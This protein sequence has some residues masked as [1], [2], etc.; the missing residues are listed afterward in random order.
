MKLATLC[1]VQ[2]GGQTL[3]LHRVKKENDVHAGKW[4]GLGGKLMPGESPEDCV[5][6]EVH[7]E[8]GLKIKNPHLR[9]ILTFPK[10]S[11]NEDWYVFVYT[12]NQFSGQ[13]IS[14]PEGDLEWIP[15][16][17]LN[18]LNLWAGDYHFLDW[19]RQNKFFSA[20]FLY[21]DGRLKS[22]SV[23]FHDKRPF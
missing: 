18:S 9:G 10:F 7:E 6:R 20:K 14:S 15:D 23:T 13:L 8:S 2:N 19:M 11:K 5:I 1:Y 12:A 3:M 16:E 22:H 4:N 17:K 21:Q